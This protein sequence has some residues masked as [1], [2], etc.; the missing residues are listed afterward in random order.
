[1][2]AERLEPFIIDVFKELHS[3][4][5]LSHEEFKTTAKIKDV[6][7]RENIE[8]LNLPLKTGLVAKIGNEEGTLVALRADIDALPIDEGTNLPYASKIPGKMH[9][10]GHDFHTAAL[11]GAALLLKNAE[12]NLKGGVLLVFQPAE[13]DARGA[14]KIIDTNALKDAKVIYGLHTSPLYP[15]GTLGV[16][17][18]PVMAAVDRFTV[19]FIGKGCHAAHPNEGVDVIPLVSEF[20]LALQT[21]ISRNSDPFAANLLSVTKI[22]AGNTWN[23][24]PD[25]AELQGTVR[26]LT[27]KDREMIKTRFYALAEGLATSFNAKVNIDWWDGPPPTINDEHWTDFAE[28]IAKKE[29]FAT[30]SVFPTLSGED[31]SEY[32]ERIPGVYIKVGTGKTHPHHTSK[33]TADPAALF[34]AAKL[35][36][37]LAKET[38]GE[39][40]GFGFPTSLSD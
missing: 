22:A 35:L 4:P 27:V 40:T 26:T 30:Q 13:E 8:V 14:L 16:S 11:L 7:Q 12:E 25:T 23:V 19:T 17:S 39:I 3:Y 31:F 37:K 21:I 38:L 9:A 2:E 18:G 28:D 32:Q 15:V 6:L 1:M 20:A 10:C 36:A 33:F 24:L 29:G 34:P 5:E